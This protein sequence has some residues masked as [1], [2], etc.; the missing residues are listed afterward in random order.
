MNRRQFLLTTTA[1]GA[2]YLSPA[3]DPARKWRVGVIG[4]TGHGDYGHG[5]DT[6]W[7]QLPETEIVAVADSNPE[8]LVK[9]RKKLGEV[10]GFGDYRQM[11]AEVKPDIV[12][13]GPRSIEQHRDMVLTAIEAGAKGIYVEKP[14]CR[15]LL[16]NDDIIKG[17]ERKGTK[18][19]VAHRNRYH[20]VLP[21]V[22]G[23]LKDNAIG[24]VLEI[25]ARGKEDARGGA[26]DLWVLGSHVINLALFFTGPATACTG[27]LYQ[28]G[29]PAIQ[30]DLRE[31]TEGVGP[32]AGN[33]VHARFETERRIP[34]FFDSVAK[35]GNSA[36]GFGL[37][38]IGTK[39]II[40][41]RADRD[42]LATLIPGSPFQPANEPRPWTPITTAGPGKPEPMEGI[43]KAVMSHTVSGRDLIAAIENGHEPLCNAKEN[44]LILECIM[45]I[46]ESHR[47]NGQRVAL[48]LK[49]RN[50]PL[51]S[52]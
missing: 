19:A 18:I 25:R 27:Q 7:L 44:R 28:D 16:E 35:A 1:A 43:G 4:N 26:Q 47:M 52:L 6:M 13:V 24:Q 23:M 32:I 38:I 29:K 17:A 21:V 42:P 22:A 14:L 40:D 9:A 31:G 37:Q 49:T 50:N 15:T 10:P 45:G 12:A 46:F 39:G 51:A 5:L 30:A 34:I 8:G 33:E 20:P 41:F 3:A 48:P 36:A 2:N 11:L